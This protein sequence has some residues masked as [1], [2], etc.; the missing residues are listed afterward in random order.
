MMFN[1][2]TFSRIRARYLDSRVFLRKQQEKHIFLMC[3]CVFSIC[4]E[5]T[6]AYKTSGIS[7]E[8][9][10]FHYNRR[11]V[12]ITIARIVVSVSLVCSGFN[13][14]VKSRFCEFQYLFESPSITRNFR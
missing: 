8:S 14:F 10:F 12:T 6:V 9:V 3:S 7:P 13:G 4:H 11:R 5:L 2:D 1:K